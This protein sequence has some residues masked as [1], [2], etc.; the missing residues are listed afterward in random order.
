MFEF[1][2]IPT[3]IDAIREGKVIVV[4]DDEDRENEG[5]LIVAASKITPEIVNF[6][7]K[8][9]RGLICVPVSSDVADKLSFP[10]MVV[11]NNEST[12]CNFTVSVDYV[13]DTTTGISASDRAKT[14]FA[15]TDSN[16]TP[17]D[18]SRPGHIFPLRAKN[19]GV[20]VRAGHTEA[21][22]DL[23]T[24]AGLPPVSAICEI[25]GHDGEMLKGE[26]LYDFARN[27]GLIIITIKDLIEYRRKSEKLVEL[28][29]ETALPTLFGDFHMKVFKNSIDD[30]EHVVLSMGD[31]A[32]TDSVLTRV[33]SE[34]LTGEVFGS[35]RCDCKPQLD[36]AL[37]AISDEGVGVLLYMR[38]EGRGIGLINKVKAYA[39]QDDGLDTVEA[40]NMLGF[41]ADLRD[42]GIGA[43]ILVEIGLKNI[44]LMTNN[45]K[46]IV[47]LDGYG[48][49]VV[50]RVPIELLPN[51]QNRKYLSTKKEKMGHILKHV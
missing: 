13:K 50:E 32:N 23:A 46:K 11:T 2:K 31:V 47:G 36:S 38:Q 39:L 3:A 6:M 40:N 12:L 37:R 28:V 25:A 1:D 4:L 10:P 24:L 17:N 48:I 15:I 30:S 7:A 21:A 14:I 43:Q 33:H 41:D 22:V 19:G 29:A 44:R 20:L 51:L 8:E 45:P 34:C 42:Y 26:G 9:G 27:N 18:F 5:D 49:N 16:S 35:L